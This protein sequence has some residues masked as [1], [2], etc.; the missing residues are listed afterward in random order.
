MHVEAVAEDRWS[1]ARISGV[2]R[3]WEGFVLSHVPKS[4]GHGAP[5]LVQDL[6]T[7]D[8]G[9]PAR[10]INLPGLGRFPMPFEL[11]VSSFTEAV[12]YVAD[13]KF[14][15]TM[16]LSYDLEVSKMGPQIRQLLAQRFGHIPDSGHMTGAGRF[17]VSLLQSP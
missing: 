8:P 4:E 2:I 14:V 15:G 11:S 17:E 16:R 5:A 3:S 1:E 6:E 9:P 13:G 10:Q 12:G 7:Q